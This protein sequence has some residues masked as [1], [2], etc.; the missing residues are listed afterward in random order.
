[1]IAGINVHPCGCVNEYQDETYGKGRRV[2][3][4]T[5]KGIRCSVCGKDYAMTTPKAEV[6][7]DTKKK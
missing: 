2:M 1:M 4:I 3:N 7:T 6:K 5:T